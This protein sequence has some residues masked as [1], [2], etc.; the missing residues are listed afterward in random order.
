MSA[1]GPFLAICA[2][3]ILTSLDEELTVY[4]Y[5]S[6]RTHPKLSPLVPEIADLL[7][8]PLSPVKTRLYQGL[9]VLR[10]ELDLAAGGTGDVTETHRLWEHPKN[11]QRV[12]SGVVQR[13]LGNGNRHW[14]GSVGSQPA[15]DWTASGTTSASSSR[16]SGVPSRSGHRSV[17]RSVEP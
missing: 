2:V 12:G 14:A 13:S 16:A 15:A 7:D 11:P 17:T 8:C 10:R 3:T 5:F 6:N 1:S 4:G 9:V